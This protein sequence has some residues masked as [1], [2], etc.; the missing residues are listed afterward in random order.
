[1]VV[2]VRQTTQAQPQLQRI[3]AVLAVQA[4]DLITRP[5]R[6]VLV[7]LVHK[8][9]Q[10]QVEAVQEFLGT[11]LTLQAPQVAQVALVAVEVG[12]RQIVG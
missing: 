4:E 9:P 10:V 2:G 6:A 3:Q 7:Q 8:T 5:T 11:A 12:R 1:V